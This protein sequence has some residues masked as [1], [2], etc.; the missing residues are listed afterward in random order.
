MHSMR[1]IYA[2][3]SPQSYQIFWG[4]TSSSR[5]DHDFTTLNQML[6]PAARCPLQAADAPLPT[7]AWF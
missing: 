6:K 3:S 4:L 7:Q 1:K 2:Q 5:F